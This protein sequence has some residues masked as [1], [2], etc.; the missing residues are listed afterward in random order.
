[1]TV[2]ASFPALAGLAVLILSGCT[3]APVDRQALMERAHYWQRANTTDAIYQRGPK[4]Q[5][6][7][8]RDIARCVLEIR[9]MERMGVLRRALPAD[10][11][12]G[13]R[14]P[15]SATPAGQ[16]AAWETPERDGYLRAEHG[17]YHDFETCMIDKGWERIDSV[18]YDV[19]ETARETYL[20]TILGEKYRTTMGENT[21]HETGETNDP[22]F[23]A[24]NE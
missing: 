15:D 12:P 5:Q 22:N 7:L 8:H 20:E 14:V 23:R 4:A 13:T 3:G 16:M 19:A 2:K 9:E 10:N 17:D 1:M 18:P 11:G 6:M 21:R 24:L